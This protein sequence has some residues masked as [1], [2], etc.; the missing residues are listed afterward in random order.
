M[1]A[2]NKHS[3]KPKEPE[4]TRRTVRASSLAAFVTS[5]L[6]LASPF[7]KTISY[8]LVEASPPRKDWSTLDLNALEEEWKTGDNAEDLITPDEHLYD[9]MERER[10]SAFERMQTLMRKTKGDTFH[11]ET[12]LKQAASDAQHAGKAVMI[13]AT[14]KNRNVGA[15]TKDCDGW[16]WNAMASIC[17]EWSVS[18]TITCI[19]NIFCR[20]LIDPSSPS[21]TRIS[22]ATLSLT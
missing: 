14:L 22:L 8:P 17:D 11:E 21:P 19:Q 20:C 13:F 3:L 5:L 7:S 10:K 1:F 12:A 9:L 4:S 6:L 2:V 16:D 18:P 15:P